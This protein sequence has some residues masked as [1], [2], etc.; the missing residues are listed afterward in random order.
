M[1][2]FSFVSTKLWIN[3]DWQLQ[4]SSVTKPRSAEHTPTLET[5]T[6]YFTIFN[7][8]LNYTCKF[9]LD[10]F[11]SIIVTSGIVSKAPEYSWRFWKSFHNNFIMHSCLKQLLL[12]IKLFDL[13]TNSFNIP[14][15]GRPSFWSAG[16]LQFGINLHFAWRLQ[17]CHRV[18]H[19]A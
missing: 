17:K 16:L 1:L 11:T 5:H 14:T 4:K 13:Q 18:S 7:L 15:T 3:S 8:L 2:H 10:I 6:F 9:V 19:E 12:S